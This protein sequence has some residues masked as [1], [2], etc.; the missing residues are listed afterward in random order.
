MTTLWRDIRD[1]RRTAL[2][3]LLAWLAIWT[4]TILTSHPDLPPAVIALHFFSLLA[5]AIVAAWWRTQAEGSR[6]GRQVLAGVLAAV[7][8]VE[9]DI[10]LLGAMSSGPDPWYSGRNLAEWVEW[11]T[12]FG[13]F[14]ALLGLFGAGVAIAI[15]LSQR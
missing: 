11:S 4:A 12:V 1:H 7:L 9:I 8:T 14:A 2:G 5:A 13:T 6:R 15:D 3:F 10:L